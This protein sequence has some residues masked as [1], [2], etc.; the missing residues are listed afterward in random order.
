MW[1]KSILTCCLMCDIISI[2]NGVYIMN[3]IQ[4]LTL[5][6]AA[7]TTITVSSCALAST[8]ADKANLIKDLSDDCGYYMTDVNY[9]KANELDNNYY[10]FFRAH[11]DNGVNLGY[12]NPP[13]YHDHMD[14]IVRYSVS[15]EDYNQVLNM[16][17][18]QGYIIV[19][20]TTHN[21]CEILNNIIHNYTPDSV[22]AVDREDTDLT[23]VYND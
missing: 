7:A 2:Y 1:F 9:A 21:E 16:H 11:Y 13:R 4:K 15:K 12:N 17:N 20:N 22:T 8:I 3:Y 10:V 18:K 6:I 14:Y 5:A 23:H 19:K